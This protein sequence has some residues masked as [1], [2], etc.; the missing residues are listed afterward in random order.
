L[1]CRHQPP[2]L[3]Q[4]SWQNSRIICQ[5]CQATQHSLPPPES[6]PQKGAVPMDS[7]A[8]LPPAGIPVATPGARRWRWTLSFSL[9]DLKTAK[10]LESVKKCERHLMQLVAFAW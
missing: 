7:A 1:D 3:H 6:F 5:V 10:R 2:N 8:S 4:K 9:W